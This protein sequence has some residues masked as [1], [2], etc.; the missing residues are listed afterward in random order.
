[1]IEIMGRS[2][3][4]TGYDVFLARELCIMCVMGFVYLRLK[5]VVFVVCDNINGVFSGLSGICC[6]YGVRSLNYYYSVF[7]FDAEEI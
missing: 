7:S 5:C 2:Y 3:L 6:L 4:C 1:M